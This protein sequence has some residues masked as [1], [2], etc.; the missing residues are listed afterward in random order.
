MSDT[1]TQFRASNE[2][3]EI[4]FGMIED[5]DALIK[6]IN[7]LFNTPADEAAFIATFRRCARITASLGELNRLVKHDFS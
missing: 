3:Q 2:A 6:H 4:V 5:A 1:A 7:D